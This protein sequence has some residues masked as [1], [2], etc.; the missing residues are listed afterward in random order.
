M[1]KKNIHY[2]EKE[3][4]LR[5]TLGIE[6]FSSIKNY[7]SIIAENKYDIII[8]VSKKAYVLYLEFKPYIKFENESC[9]YCNDTAISVLDSLLKK[10]PK[11]EKRNTKIAVIDDILIH[12]RTL[13]SIYKK[14]QGLGYTIDLFAFC[15]NKDD[16][17]SLN[18]NG[19]IP[20]LMEELREIKQKTRTYYVCNS[21][22]WKYISNHIIRSFW[23]TNI[24]YISFLPYLQL[25]V[26]GRKK[27]I[28][29]VDSHFKSKCFSNHS[30]E[31]LGQ[32]TI[33]FFSDTTLVANDITGLPL[34]VLQTQ[35]SLQSYNLLSFVF[36]SEEELINNGTQ[37][38]TNLFDQ[39]KNQ[40]LTSMQISLF[41]QLLNQGENNSL[42]IDRE[43][44]LKLTMS[45]F[46]LIGLKRTI[47][48]CGISEKDYTV[49]WDNIFYSFGS[50]IQSFMEN[51]LNNDKKY[52]EFYQNSLVKFLDKNIDIQNKQLGYELC[53]AVKMVNKLTDSDCIS[54]CEYLK[55]I[56]ARYLKKNSELD[57]DAIGSKR[58][59]IPGF[60]F[61][62]LVS[63]S[64]KQMMK[65][66]N[67]IVV[68]LMNQ[69]FIGAAN[70]VVQSGDSG[71]GLYYHSGEQSYKCVIKEFVPLVYFNDLF[72]R[73]FERLYANLLF[74]ILIDFSEEN[75][76]YYNIP[77]LR[78]DLNQYSNLASENVYTNQDIKKY[79][80]DKTMKNIC[81]VGDYLIDYSFCLAENTNEN[82]YGLRTTNDNF[83]RIQFVQDF[84]EYVRQIENRG[85]CNQIT[86][87]LSNLLT[88]YL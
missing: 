19:K 22:E 64:Q 84:K 14:L 30:Q 39:L 54:D 85:D 77:F 11:G 12:G 81:L 62:D 20:E 47:D 8:F 21:F 28:S 55:N 42:T 75:Y 44:V 23:A 27:L 70:L 32:Q 80:K 73:R 49:N 51:I 4:A 66:I 7:F 67:S 15:K 76:K 63:I 2:H 79:E 37:I 56:Y 17:F 26:E 25:T 61:L 87:L 43:F 68:S 48:Q 86:T 24:P 10:Q 65:P 36:L 88:K 18:E 41:S 74:E 34:F 82:I 5:E 72:Q 60:K 31:E 35:E 53:E 33:Y 58:E 1:L 78:D 45:V 69:Y 52:N 16:E 3:K 38:I 59:R 57:D 29:F 46:S 50:E 71:C 40:A 6:I 83:T 9:I 13:S